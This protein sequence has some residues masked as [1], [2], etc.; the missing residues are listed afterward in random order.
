M[1]RSLDIAVLRAHLATETAYADEI[2]HANDVAA[3]VG[4]D[5]YFTNTAASTSLDAINLDAADATDTEILEYLTS[6]SASNP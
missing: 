6:I 4:K 1:V 3:H 2:T 5:A